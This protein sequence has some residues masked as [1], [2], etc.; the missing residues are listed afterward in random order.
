[1]ARVLFLSAG[2]IVRRVT[3][4]CMIAATLL[5]AVPSHAQWGM[6]FPPGNTGR[7]NQ[8]RRP[9]NRTPSLPANLPRVEASGTVLGITGGMIQLQT[10]AGQTWRLMPARE[11]KITVTGKAKP[12]VLRPGQFVAFV[13]DVDTRTGKVPEKVTQLKI[14]TV[15]QQMQLGVFP[16]GQAPLGAGE[17]EGA[18][19]LAGRVPG[20]GGAGGAPAG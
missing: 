2:R 8:Q 18:Q 7:P 13:A 1:M 9:Q 16:E 6:P 4:A 15:S 5:Y 20:F 11:C 14:F 17:G 19:G 10:P 3:T 12:E